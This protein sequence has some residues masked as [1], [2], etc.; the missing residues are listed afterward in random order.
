MGVGLVWYGFVWWRLDFGY[1]MHML[2]LGGS[3]DG[4]V[5]RGETT[6]S[7]CMTN[8][9]MDGQGFDGRSERI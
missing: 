8:F 1:C 6:P 5:V 3:E 2:V 7:R 4:T 9:Q